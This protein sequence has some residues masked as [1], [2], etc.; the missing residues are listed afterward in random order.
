MSKNYDVVVLGGGT[1]GYVAAIQAAKNGQTVAVVEKAKIGGTCLHQGCIPTKALLRSAEVFQTVKKAAEF[2]VE[3]SGL[4]SSTL[5][6]LKVQERKQSIV[7]QL[8]RGIHGLFKQGNIDLYSGE[9]TI[10]GTSIFEPKAGTVS[11]PVAGQDNEMLVPK[12]LII[13]TG[14]RP[15][16]L[17][18]L[19]FDED[20]ILSSDGMLALKQLPKSLIIIGGGVIGMEWASMLCDFGV[21]VTVLEYAEQIIP[22]EDREIGKELLRSLKKRQVAIYPGA[23]VSGESLVRKAGLVAVDAVIKGKSQTFT[24]EKIMVSVGRLANI[25]TIG[26]QNTKIE[27]EKGFIKVNQVCQT[28]EP[29][30]YAIGDI[31][32]TAQLAHVA[33]HEGLLAA[34]H[35]SGKPVTPLAYDDIAKCVYTS[36]EVASLGLSEEQAKERGFAVKTGKFNFRANGK[37]L[38]NGTA[39]GFVKVVADQATNDLLGVSVIGPH[40]TD[41][42]SE[43]ALARFLDATPWE[44]GQTIHPHP[45]LSEA[46]GEAAL[47]VDGLAIHG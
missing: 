22:N 28:K 6:F 29:H 34:N 36:P 27:T 35:L 7:D 46:L 42:I 45:T 39:D 30:I 18:G 38:V 20:T 1:G 15:K 4:A 43:A 14:S 41:L 3:S 33:M 12:Q 10:L 2:G 31:I 19:L 26:L 17:P 11:V 24:A 8:E 5:N 9:G 13:A 21:A 37:A 40:A 44:I 23:A 16:A 47:M 32:P 25:E